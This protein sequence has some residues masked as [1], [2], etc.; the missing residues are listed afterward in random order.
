MAQDMIY[1][2]GC[3]L[4]KHMFHLW[5]GESVSASGTDLLIGRAQVFAFLV[6]FLSTCSINRSRTTLGSALVLVCSVF[7]S[8]LLEP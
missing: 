3:A 1:F 7:A 2:D 6:E 8:D 5:S 4:E